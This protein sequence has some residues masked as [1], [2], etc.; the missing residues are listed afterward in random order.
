LSETLKETFE[1]N[2]QEDKEFGNFYE[3]MKRKLNHEKKNIKIVTQKTSD[4]Y[5]NKN[6]NKKNSRLKKRMNDLH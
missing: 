2:I 4:F 6:K 5:S 1:V 3:K